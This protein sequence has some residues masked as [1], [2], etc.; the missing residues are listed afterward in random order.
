MDA[1]SFQITT[2]REGE[3]ARLHLAGELDLARVAQLDQAVR[4]A[5][6]DSGR[7]EIDLRDLSFIDSS[8]L[9]ALMDIHNVAESDGLSYALIQ[10][11][12]EVHRTFELTGLASV[13]HFSAVPR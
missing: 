4:E 3:V 9:R 10:G 12:P 1:G 11:P 13:F 2:E 7:I 8:G 5:W 6:G